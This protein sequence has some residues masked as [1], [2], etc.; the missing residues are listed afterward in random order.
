L[1]AGTVTVLLPR[2]LCTLF[3]GAPAELAVAAGTVAEMMAA[4][5]ARFPGMRDRLVDSTPRIRRHINVFVGDDRASLDTVLPPGSE[6]VV[7]TAIS[8]G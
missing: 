2:A 1:A 5:D 4:L 6:V 7:M 3:P 8:G